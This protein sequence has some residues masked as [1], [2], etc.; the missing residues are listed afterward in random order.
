MKLDRQ[1]ADELMQRLQAQWV[2]AE[3]ARTL[4]A[5]A[6]AHRCAALNGQYLG[7]YTASRYVDRAWP[8]TQHCRT[9]Y[10][11]PQQPYLRR[12]PPRHRGPFRSGA[13]A[14]SGHPEQRVNT[15]KMPVVVLLPPVCLE[16][17]SPHRLLDELRHTFPRAVFLIDT[18]AATAQWLPDDVTLLQPAL[19]IQ[20]EQAQLDL[21]DDTKDFIDR[22]LYGSA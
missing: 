19:D 5:A 18:G 7:T 8:L 6:V 22:K 1:F 15:H 9:G 17:Q 10:R 16:G 2:S 14:S 21:F 20:T 11:S 4:P 3:A 13:H 12:N